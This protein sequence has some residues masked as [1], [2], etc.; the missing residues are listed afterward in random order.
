MAGMADVTDVTNETGGT[1]VTDVTDGTGVADVADVTGVPP[2]RGA[3]HRLDRHLGA[4]VRL[5]E[6]GGEQIGRARVR[7]DLTPKGSRAERII[8]KAERPPPR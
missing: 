8:G 3:R 6:Q 7:I 4:L 2:F 5:C 1:G